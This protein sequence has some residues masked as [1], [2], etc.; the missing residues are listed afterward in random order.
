[1]DKMQERIMMVAMLNDAE[2]DMAKIFIDRMIETRR[3]F[4]AS[5]MEEI[6]KKGK[7]STNWNQSWWE[8]ILIMYLLLWGTSDPD[9]EKEISDEQSGQDVR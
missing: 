5:S 9:K 8:T 7:V 6:E 3:R 1:M 2:W 4:T